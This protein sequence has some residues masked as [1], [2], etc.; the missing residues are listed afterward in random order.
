[1]QTRQRYAIRGNVVEDVLIGALRIL[2]A[3]ALLLFSE[4]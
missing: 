3:S 1:M 4:T 2:S